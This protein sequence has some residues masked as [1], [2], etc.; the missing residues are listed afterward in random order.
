[1]LGNTVLV[2]ENDEET[3]RRADYVVDLGPGAGSHGGAVVALGAP[4]DVAANPQSITGLYMR[5]ELKIPVP[6]ERRLP[7][8][9]TITVR[10]AR[11]NNLKEIDVSFPLGLLT[12][13]TGV[14]GS[15]KSTLVADILYRALAR[16][17]YGSL[18]EP[19]AHEA[20]EGLE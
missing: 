13:V 17:V 16:S 8:G 7:N 4:A 19:G 1:G 12:V 15:G 18:A 10:G 3:I 11:H 14:S 9:K 5:G 6:S 2:V 20:I